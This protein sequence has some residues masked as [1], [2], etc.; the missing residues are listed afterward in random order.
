MASDCGHDYVRNESNSL[1]R[2]QIVIKARIGFPGA[3]DLPGLTRECEV[4]ARV[5]YLCAVFV[6]W[7]STVQPQN[8]LT[9]RYYQPVKLCGCMVSSAYQSVW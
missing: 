5:L 1:C 9:L 7:I 2:L 4:D 3:E 6:V 8:Y